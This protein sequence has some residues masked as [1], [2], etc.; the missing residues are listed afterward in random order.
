LTKGSSSTSGQAA[1]ESA[2]VLPL[3]IFLV[4]GLIQLFVVMQARVLA[5]YAVGR[6]VRA[7]AL[8]FAS[9]PAMQKTAI[10]IL[11]PA[12]N[13]RFATKSRGSPRGDAY[14]NAV[15]DRLGNRY[16]PDVDGNRDGPIV[17]MWRISPLASDITNEEED[18]WNLAPPQGPEH[19]LAVRMVFWAPLNIPFA[20]WVFARMALAQW[21]LLDYTKVNPLAPT[22]KANWVH[23][24]TFVPTVGD[25]MKRRYVRQQYVFPV[26]T[27]AALRMMSPARF[28]DQNCP[29]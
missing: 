9:C 19:V 23:E 26:E 29:L 28:T 12:I 1:V 6:A 24:G 14:A 16:Q 27:S 21:G 25:E 5:Q 15:I 17:W 13:S 18:V 11:L 3:V 8:N 2:I 20:N 7:G 10:A 4:L 22:Q